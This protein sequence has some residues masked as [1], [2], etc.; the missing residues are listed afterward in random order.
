MSRAR[1]VRI[2]AV[3]GLALTLVSM[4]PPS[5]SRTGADPI[6]VLLVGDSVTQGSAGDWTWRYRLWHHLVDNGTAVDLVGPRD[7]L[8]DNVTSTQGSHAYADPAFDTDH[9]S[10]WGMTFAAQDVPIGDLVEEYH[11]DVVVE[12]LGVN[13]LAWD[14]RSATE[15]AA[16]A[17]RFV[18]DA[19]VADPTVAVVLGGLPQTWIPGAQEYDASLPALADELSTDTSP[20]V[21]ASPEQPFVEGVDTYDAAHPTATGELRIAAGVADALAVLG[22]GSPYPRPLPTVPNGPRVPATLSVRAGDGEATLTWQSPP[23]ATAEYVWI[24]DAT[25]GEPW[26]RL[27]Y[28]LGASTFTAGGLTNYDDYQF[29]LQAE[30]GSVAAEDLYSDVVTVTPQRPA[31]GPVPGPEVGALD[32]GL[33]VTWGASDMATSY[34]VSWAPS[35]DPAAVTVSTVTGLSLEIG[36]LQAGLAY[37]VGI[38]PVNDRTPGP[39]AGLLATPTGPVPAAPEGLSVRARR[40]RRL[41]VRWD[42]SVEATAYQLLRRRDDGWRV[43]RTTATTRFVTTPVRTRRTV[44]L[45]VRAV[46]QHLLGGTTATARIRLGRP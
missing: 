18:E 42:P 21:V 20:V 6:R 3:A 10:R 32:H 38:E 43:A 23:G 26:G 4:A 24:R 31:P 19:R 35:D 37:R 25:T 30:K 5:V 44:A 12:Q 15:V 28:A 39:S 33:L 13:D 22:V 27:P 40:D 11:P 34:R 8:L 46:H 14:R 29:R 41:V 1:G 9:A 17:R 36:S 16:F 45:R 2:A 7:D